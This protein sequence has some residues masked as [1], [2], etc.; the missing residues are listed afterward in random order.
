MD[1]P[2]E[3][4]LE[5]ELSPEF[6]AFAVPLDEA[7]A[8]TVDLV[9]GVAS[10]FGE[11]LCDRFGVF[12]GLGLAAPPA[13]PH[14]V[15]PPLGTAVAAVAA[16]AVP[17]GPTLADPDAATDCDVPMLG[18]TGGLLAGLV[19]EAGLDGLAGVDVTT[20]L[21]VCGEVLADATAEADVAHGA[22]AE[23]CW[24]GPAVAPLLLAAPSAA[25]PAEPCPSVVP[26]PP[27]LEVC[28]VST[29]EPSWTM[30]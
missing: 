21:L 30:A 5:S 14:P 26:A 20:G 9:V 10:A 17:L 7:D 6:A 18:L 29:D 15:S 3:V 23:G 12:A 16:V 24:V 4:L 19:A 27:P 13:L 11:A 1:L 28:P 8:D 22:A 2:G 25:C